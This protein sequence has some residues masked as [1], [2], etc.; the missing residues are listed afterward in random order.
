MT[1]R[2]AILDGNSLMHR[3]FHAVPAQM[4]A[5]DGQPTN[6]VFGFFSM[7]L[8]LID[9][10]E[11]SG[12]VVAFDHGVPAFRL[13][14]IEQYKAQR[15]PT[16]PDLKSQFPVI[17]ELLQSIRIPVVELEGW[18][19]DDIMGTL[20]QTCR[21]AD[22]ECLLVTGDKDALQLVDDNTRVVNTRTGLSDVVVY[23]EAAVFERWGV[24]PQLVPDFLGLMGDSSDNIP[25]VPGV[26]EK[27][28]RAL[29]QQ[30]GTLDAVLAH[31]DEIKGKLGESLRENAD[32]A[33]AS[34]EV[35]TIRLDVPVSLDVAAAT[36]P[37]YNAAEVTQ[38]F[39]K[40]A[41]T[42][43]LRKMLKLLE[44]N[45][46]NTSNGENNELLAGSLSSVVDAGDHAGDAPVGAVATADDAAGFDA[47]VLIP[48]LF[49]TVN[50]DAIIY[51][52]GD[53]A[54]Q[55]LQK[56]LSAQVTIAVA[57]D[58]SASQATLFD[59]F[60]STLFCATD[61]HI[62]N[63]GQIDKWLSEAGLEPGV[64]ATG[65][66]VLLQ[67]VLAEAAAVVALDLKSLLDFC[68][69]PTDLK[70]GFATY[71]AY[72]SQ[73]FFD[74]QLAAYILDST[75]TPTTLKSLCEAYDG[76]HAEL[77]V[78]GGQSGEIPETG[79]LCRTMLPIAALQQAR[80]LEDQADYLFY[81][82]EM[83]LLFVLA[84]MQR[85]GVHVDTAV[86]AE[87][88][89]AMSEEIATLKD[90]ATAAAGYEFNLDSPRQ[91]AEVLFEKL[92]LP[93]T[94][95]TK[96]GY[97][98]D[99]SVLEDLKQLHPLPSLM[100]EYREL[101]KLKSTYLDALPRLVAADGNIHTTFNQTVTATGRLSSTDPNLQNIPI[102]KA[103]G[104]EI[105]TAFVPGSVALARSEALL[106]SADYSQIELRLLAHLSQDPGLVQAFRQG[107]DFHS[108]TAS[109][110]WSVALADV[111]PELRSRAKAVNFGIVY[112]QQAYGLSQSL[113]ISMTEAQKLIDR[114]FTTFPGVRDYLD[115]TVTL[116]HAQGWVET[117]F[118]RRRYI[119]E[120]A[121]SNANQRHFGERTAMNHPM[122]GSAADIIKLAMVEVAKNLLTDGY[123]SELILQVH[124][125]LV[126]NCAVDELHALT[127]MVKQTMEGVVELQVPLVV[128][129]SSGENWA[130]AH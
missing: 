24:T 27:K 100:L 14:A 49:K 7:L 9:T 120:L 17:Q 98:T 2:I 40:L 107:T 45:N 78:H 66:N 31:A 63:L 32:L 90:K 116:A 19:G 4:T 6:A 80:L 89:R 102:R 21:Q 30:Y 47:P 13:Q 12:I 5:P 41:M 91:L 71:T 46:Q 115:Q 110:V 82:V 103:Q 109:Q 25:G 62:L 53:S 68:A 77:T 87:L 129:I 122:Q 18:E 83:P 86:L 55:Q 52:E 92:N 1:K 3:A 81:Q 95:K 93:A 126:F 59:S 34:R 64:E 26:G 16:D 99:A 114:Y 123:R 101:T 65:A 15:P 72:G 33:R 96:S 35:A 44:K 29:L 48:T 70:S 119:R 51:L 22:I 84:D 23:D 94:K 106:V 60:G 38:A 11:V 127:A 88:N 67:S 118:R 8:K 124:D 130:E 111:S 54:R 104:R 58:S 74:C 112:G 43:H 57:L 117:I 97:S 69:P 125:E 20:S 113:G 79:L 76:L 85:I 28:A 10:F 61:S 121:L 73:R 39:Q 42:S 50:T 36:F 108:A 128:D 56:A 37:A 105:R 75:D